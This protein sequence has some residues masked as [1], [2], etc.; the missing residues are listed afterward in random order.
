MAVP[1]EFKDLTRGTNKFKVRYLKCFFENK[2]IE[3][4]FKN[5]SLWGDGYKPIAF[6]LGNRGQIISMD[7]SEMKDVFCVGLVN[8]RYPAPPHPGIINYD[9]MNFYRGDPMSY[10][11]KDLILDGKTLEKGW[12]ISPS[13]NLM[14]AQSLIGGYMEKHSSDESESGDHQETQDGSHDVIVD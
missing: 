4:N 14:R 7:S 6:Y 3:G 1:F 5:T 12:I 10:L 13:F 8:T 11:R 9:M 2:E